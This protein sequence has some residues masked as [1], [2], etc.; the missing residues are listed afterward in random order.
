MK[1]LQTFEMSVTTFQSA[2]HNM[3]EDF[4]LHLSWN[5]EC[6][7]AVNYIYA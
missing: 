3:P 6:T 1:A 5:G 7:I 4:K 2:Q